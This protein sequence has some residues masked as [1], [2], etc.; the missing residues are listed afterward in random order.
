MR[1]SRV[2]VARGW[3]VPLLVEG[4]ARRVHV[5]LRSARVLGLAGQWN[6]ASRCT[7]V[8]GTIVALALP[9]SMH[10]APVQLLNSALRLPSLTALAKLHTEYMATAVQ[11]LLS[12]PRK[13]SSCLTRLGTGPTSRALLS[14]CRSAVTSSAA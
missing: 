5:E 2:A 11:A 7:S 4:G 1:P 10:V 6:W 3:W 14:A 9:G 12:A 13:R 8:V